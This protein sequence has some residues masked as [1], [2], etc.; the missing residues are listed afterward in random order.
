MKILVFFVFSLSL[1][2]KDFTKEYHPSGMDSRREYRGLAGGF[3]IQDCYVGSF[4]KEIFMMLFIDHV[5]L[6]GEAL[7]IYSQAYLSIPR[8]KGSSPVN[9]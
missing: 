4:Y 9:S 5:I 8:V 6:N 3:L 1:F 2:L 7:Y